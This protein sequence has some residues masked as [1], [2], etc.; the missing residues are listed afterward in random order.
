[1]EKFNIQPKQNRESKNWNRPNIGSIIQKYFYDRNSP[2][3]LDNLPNSLLQKSR[4]LKYTDASGK[5]VRC[6]PVS[7]P[8]NISKEPQ[9]KDFKKKML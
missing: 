1:M 6:Y 2:L 4:T 9:S 3:G 5:M 8:T 7:Q